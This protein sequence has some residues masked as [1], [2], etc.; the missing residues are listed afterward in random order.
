MANKVILGDTDTAKEY[1]EDSYESQGKGKDKMMISA[2]KGLTQENENKELLGLDG[3]TPTPATFSHGIRGAK[4]V[5]SWEEERT[6][7]TVPLAF[8]RNVIL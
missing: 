4:G 1:E 7:H 3:D 2:M 6:H 5:S 8:P